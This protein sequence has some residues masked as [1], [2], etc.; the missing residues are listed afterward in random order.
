[1]GVS[2][3]ATNHDIEIGSGVFPSF[4]SWSM[5]CLRVFQTS[6]PNMGWSFYCYH[7]STWPQPLPKLYQVLFLSISWL[8]SL[9]RQSG[10]SLKCE[11]DCI[12]SQATPP[13]LCKRRLVQAP[14]PSDRR[15]PD[16]PGACARGGGGWKRR[17]PHDTPVF[18]KGTSGPSEDW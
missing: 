17:E 13:A 5:C 11:A 1:V 3:G 14:G 9:F 8:Q 18:G 10:A 15:F 6:A 16:F 2:V 4:C 12:W 7:R